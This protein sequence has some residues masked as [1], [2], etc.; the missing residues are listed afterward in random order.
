MSEIIKVSSFDEKQI[1]AD[2]DYLYLV[3]NRGFMWPYCKKH[4]M[5]LHQ[6]SK[7]M[8]DKKIKVVVVV[9]ENEKGLDKYLADN[10]LNLTFVPDPKHQIADKYQQQVKILRLG[11]MPAQV[12]LDTALNK[13]YQHFAKS[14]SDIIEEDEIFST[15]K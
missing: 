12:V 8:A 11:R 2:N 1:L 13:V 14:M 10:H 15:L 9:P 3:F 4:M 7:A 6:N 5:Q